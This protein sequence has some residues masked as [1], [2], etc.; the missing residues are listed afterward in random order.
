[1]SA[2][3]SDTFGPDRA[4][5]RPILVAARSPAAVRQHSLDGNDLLLG[6]DGTR[7]ARFRVSPGD[8]P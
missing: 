6:A 5:P 8:A 1:M 2:W 3:W 4:V 7:L